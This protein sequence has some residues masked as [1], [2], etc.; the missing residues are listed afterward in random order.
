MGVKEPYGRVI[1]RSERIE[2]DGN[3]KGR[4]TLSTNLDLWELPES[5]PPAKEHTQA[6]PSPCI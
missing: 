2:G 4:Q 5:E 6:R 1:G 3:P